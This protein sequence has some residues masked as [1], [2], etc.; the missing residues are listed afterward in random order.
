MNGVVGLGA[1]TVP[2]APG[3]S[4]PSKIEARE[5]R[6]PNIST[7]IHTNHEKYIAARK[8]IG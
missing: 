8:K 5:S 4:G 2:A 1:A 3:L 7:K 6:S